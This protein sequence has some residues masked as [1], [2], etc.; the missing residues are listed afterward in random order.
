MVIIMHYK[1]HQYAD[2]VTASVKTNAYRDGIKRELAA[3]LDEVSQMRMRQTDEEKAVRYATELLGTPQA[4][5][6]KLDKSVRSFY[7]GPAV[8]VF[9]VLAVIFAALSVF[10]GMVDESPLSYYFVCFG[11]VPALAVA[12]CAIYERGFKVRNIVNGLRVSS[13]AA[14]VGVAFQRGY[15]VVAYA[16]T[17]HHS[18]FGGN[19]KLI[20]TGN[21]LTVLPFLAI[22]FVLFV[23][24]T[25]V[26]MPIVRSVREKEVIAK[27]IFKAEKRSM[28]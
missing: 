13:L 22:G 4:L 7:G 15:Y 18:Y 10:A 12:W 11:L 24:F 26:R 16:A 20:N 1:I 21:I 23:V 3:Q 17:R 9:G 6:A 8:I 2:S 5:A 28:F 14:G 27:M 25:L 19:P